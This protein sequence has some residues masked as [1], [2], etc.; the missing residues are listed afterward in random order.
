M[1]EGEDERKRVKKKWLEK[2]KFA[3]KYKKSYNESLTFS[4]RSSQAFSADTTGFINVWSVPENNNEKVV[5]E[6]LEFEVCNNKE[7]G[8]DRIQNL[9]PTCWIKKKFN[10]PCFSL[11]GAAEPWTDKSGAGIF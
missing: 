9:N 10:V 8:I 1:G 2:V 6:K 11:T 3:G 7:P 4:S 5:I